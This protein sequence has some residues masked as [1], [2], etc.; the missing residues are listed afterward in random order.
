MCNCLVEMHVEK[1]INFV[2]LSNVHDFGLNVQAIFKE[3]SNEKEQQD[4][5]VLR[6]AKL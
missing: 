5:C 2:V 4:L 3:K 6:F 1:V